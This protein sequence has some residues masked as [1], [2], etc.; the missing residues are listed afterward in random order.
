LG[1][2][3]NKNKG[4]NEKEIKKMEGKK[5]K[6]RR[7]ETGCE[8]GKDKPTASLCAD[9]SIIRNPGDRVGSWEGRMGPRER[10]KVGTALRNRIELIA[11][12]KKI[13]GKGPW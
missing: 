12:K 10:R 13:F 2:T 3:Q 8:K 6:S 11:H 9:G 5:R 7:A 1:K 4:S